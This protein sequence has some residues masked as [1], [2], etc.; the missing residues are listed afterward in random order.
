M[1]PYVSTSDA[2]RDVLRLARAMS[3]KSAVMELPFGGG[4][5]VILGDPLRD[6]SDA[7]LHAMGRAVDSLGGRYVMA[8]DVGTTVRD[9]DLVREVTAHAAG[10]AGADGEPCPA[11]AWGV[12]HGIRAVVRHSLGRADLQGVRVAVQGLGSVGGR[13][14]RILSDAGAELVVTDLRRDLVERVADEVHAEPVAPGDIL[15][16][17]VDV[18]A[19]CAMGDVFND[20]T[21]PTLRCRAIAGGA[22]NQLGAARHADALRKRGIVYA[23][24]YVVNAGGLI[25]VAHEGPS[26]NPAAVVSACARIYDTVLDILGEADRAGTSPLA[27]ADAIAEAR[28]RTGR[29]FD[30]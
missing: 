22:N 3:Y 13:L 5:S 10:V 26:Y 20:E 9:M 2:L 4:K 19:P 11:T 24:D 27:V 17:D 1:Y 18:L 30:G 15:R 6:K 23:P 21:I 12:F 8:D 7:L 16:A 28:M 29:G 14:A 25:D